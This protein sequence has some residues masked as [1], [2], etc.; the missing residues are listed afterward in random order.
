MYTIQN[1]TGEIFTV[2]RRRGHLNFCQYVEVIK[3]LYRNYLK[4]SQCKT[5]LF[6]Y[7]NSL[8]WRHKQL[9]PGIRLVG[10]LI[11]VW[12][13]IG[14][15]LNAIPTESESSRGH[16]RKHEKPRRSENIE[17]AWF[18]NSHRRHV[19]CYGF[20]VPGDGLNPVI[21]SGQVVTWVF[22]S[23]RMQYN[24]IVSTQ[25]SFFVRMLRQ[26]M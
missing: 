22:R 14:N 11:A 25:D 17:D 19:I 1:Y 20:T 2:T 23:F 6:Q 9:R 8:L 24:G 12:V 26:Y 13:P 15:W 21:H 7:F 3:T 18:G 4:F 5:Y 16:T 10:F